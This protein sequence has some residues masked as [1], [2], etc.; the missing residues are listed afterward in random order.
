M[1]GYDS[2]LNMTVTSTPEAKAGG[3]LEFKS[4]PCLETLP[5]P[6]SPR[7]CKE[8]REKEI[9]E[10]YQQAPSFALSRSPLGLCPS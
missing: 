1:M 3:S 2:H 7:T 10:V 9:K 4:N 8:R 6:T 5:T